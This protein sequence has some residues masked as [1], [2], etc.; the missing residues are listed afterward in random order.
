MWNKSI[1]SLLRMTFHTFIDSYK[2]SL[3]HSFVYSF[4]LPDIYSNRLY[5]DASIISY[6]I[7]PSVHSFIHILYRR[8]IHIVIH[9][10]II[11]D[12]WIHSS[13]HSSA[14]LF[15]RSSFPTLIH[16]FMDLFIYLSIHKYQFIRAFISLLLIHAFIYPF[17]MH[18]SFTCPIRTV[19]SLVTELFA[20]PGT[21][22]WSRSIRFQRSPRKT[23]IISN[24]L[25]LDLSL[26]HLVI[27]GI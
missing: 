7:H 8:F 12:I 14:Y 6:I 24:A 26:S 2:N 18:E 25:Q 27:C 3:I 17:Y 19:I 1:F 23:G 5:K 15:I 20:S 4:I 21:A 13:I 22:R 16:H 11:I 9:S 10:L